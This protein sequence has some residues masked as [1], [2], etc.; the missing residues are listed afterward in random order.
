[1]NTLRRNNKGEVVKRLQQLLAR[2]GYS[3][4][5]QDGIFG[6]DTEVAVKYFQYKH[7]LTADGIMGIY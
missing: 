7:G 1:M 2:Q 3:R 5:L 4:I 6:A